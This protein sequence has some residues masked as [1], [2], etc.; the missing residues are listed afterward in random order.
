MLLV[1][2]LNIYKC[3]DEDVTGEQGNV[4]AYGRLDG[5]YTHKN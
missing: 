1:I 2:I 4:I 5:N 3:M